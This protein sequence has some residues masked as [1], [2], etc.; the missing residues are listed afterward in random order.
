MV[1]K[2]T[3]YNRTNRIDRLN[4]ACK[5]MINWGDTKMYDRY[6]GYRKTKHGYFIKTR[7]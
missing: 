3:K 4:K 6:L 7:L 1:G 2:I 5:F